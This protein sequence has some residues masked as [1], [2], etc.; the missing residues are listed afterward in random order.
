GVLAAASP[1]LQDAV[2]AGEN[3]DFIALLA[4]PH[5]GGCHKPI[6]DHLPA[7]DLAPPPPPRGHARACISRRNAAHSGASPHVP[8]PLILA[9]PPS[10]DANEITDKGYINQRLALERR[11]ADVE[12]LFASVPDEDVIVV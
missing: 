1:A 8:P 2:V 3:R 9:D 4:W 6:G 5:A 12:R 11:N 10:I 7:A